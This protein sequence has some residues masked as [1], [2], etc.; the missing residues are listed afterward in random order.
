M[1]E[2]IVHDIFNFFYNAGKFTAIVF[3]FIVF[4]ALLKTIF[5]I[6]VSFIKDNTFWLDKYDK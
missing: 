6:A 5:D 2:L 1:F 3:G 4:T